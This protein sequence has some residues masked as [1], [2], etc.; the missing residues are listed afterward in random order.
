MFVSIQNAMTTNQVL[1]S[2]SLSLASQRG[3]GKKVCKVRLRC[4]S[5]EGA[6]EQ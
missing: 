6:Q 2:L 5:E 3:G 4:V 1:L